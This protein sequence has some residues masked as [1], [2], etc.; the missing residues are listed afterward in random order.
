MVTSFYKN[1]AK[2]E[3]ILWKAYLTDEAKKDRRT[4]FGIC[5]EEKRAEAI[6][7]PL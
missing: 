4:D 2:E 6:R 1:V 5:H 3:I 7:K